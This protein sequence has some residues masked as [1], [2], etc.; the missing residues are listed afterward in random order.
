MSNINGHGRFLAI[1]PGAHYVAIDAVLRVERSGKTGM[2][3]LRNGEQLPL[4]ADELERVLATLATLEN[5]E[6][7]HV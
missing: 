5:D 2:L 6:V 7:N 3:W 1:V 4:F